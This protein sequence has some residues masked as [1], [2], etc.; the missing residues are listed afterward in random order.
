[1]TKITFVPQ[2]KKEFKRLSRKYASLEADIKELVENLLVKP[3]FGTPLGGNV[4][5]I[6]WPV[7]SKG[8]GKSGGVRVI[9]YFLAE[10]GKLY[11]L[12]IYD[13]SE[14][15]SITSKQIRLLIETIL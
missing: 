7:K 6:R 15:E 1:M 11:L 10:D 4:F 12:S 14:Q 5:K 8:K 2:F 3:D 9:T 13:K